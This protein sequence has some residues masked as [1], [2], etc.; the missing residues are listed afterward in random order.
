MLALPAPALA[1]QSPSPSVEQYV[2]RVPT[3]EGAKPS[4]NGTYKPGRPLPEKVRKRL[5]EEAGAD[6]QALED[7]ATAE[8]LGAPASSEEGSGS[9]GAPAGG[10][11]GQDDQRGDRPQRDDGA[12]APPVAATDDG[13]KG[14]VP[15]IADAAF[16][17][18]SDSTPLLLVGLLLTTAV[19]AGAAVARRRAGS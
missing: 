5:R 18:D 9:G 6:A 15:A 4:G 10:S 14:T 17:T 7:V 3:A 19:M 16:G 2:E 1:Q 13:G 8:G 12:A 11:G